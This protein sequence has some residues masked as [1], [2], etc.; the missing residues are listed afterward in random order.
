MI[1]AT[2]GV[3]EAH[4]T[5][6]VRF[7]VV[8]SVYVPVAVN[9]WVAPLAI[10]GFAGVTAID[11]SVAAVTVSVV[12][13]ADRHRRGRR[14]RRV[15]AASSVARPAAVIVATVVVAE[16]HVTW[17]VRF[18]V[19]PS[20]NVPVA[21]NCCVSALGDRSDSPASPR[22]TPASRPS[23]SA[24]SSR[25]IAADVAV[26]VD[27]PAATSVARPA[28]VIVATVVRR[29]RPRHLARQV[30]RR[31]VADRSRSP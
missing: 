24:S 7:C 31:A 8:P 25:V 11:C 4:V 18:C 30:L 23:P 10:D 20:V 17:L 26:I 14:D 9:C 15:P 6:L 19:V 22:S 12:D 16:V 3:A 1:V 28:C 5:W 13:A 21:V 29:R 27:V 2:D